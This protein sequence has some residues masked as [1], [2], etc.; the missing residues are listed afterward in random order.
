MYVVCL[1]FVLNSRNCEANIWLL[2]MLS[3]LL[4]YL[5]TSTAVHENIFIF[6]DFCCLQCLIYRIFSAFI[7]DVFLPLW[8]SAFFYFFY[9]LL[10]GIQRPT[11]AFLLTLINSLTFLFETLTLRVVVVNAVSLRMHNLGRSL[12]S[13]Q[14]TLYI[15]V[16]AHTHDTHVLMF[17][18]IHMSMSCTCCCRC[19]FCDYE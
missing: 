8:V 10:M 7:V 18:Y 5:Q 3:L 17:F 6:L 19:R 1:G 12:P 16:Y 14:L 2:L 15:C 4:L 11:T 9:I 13:H